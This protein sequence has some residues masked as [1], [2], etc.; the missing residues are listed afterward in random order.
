[1]QAPP[2]KPPVRKRAAVKA[3]ADTPRIK[4]KAAA[5]APVKEKPPGYVFGRPTSYRAEYCDDVIRMGG[6][7]FSI[8]EMAAEIGVNR[9]TLEVE[10][11]EKWPDF[12]RAFAQARLLSQAWWERQGRN[13]LSADKF[14]ASLY[15]RS[16]AARFP[17]DWRETS[18]VESTGKDG[19]KIEVE[20]TSG[21]AKEI[22]ALLRARKTKSDAP[23]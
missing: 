12:S 1:M 7:G 15:S 5:A 9:V 22:M 17:A 13:G 11:P 2:K 20:T 4:I 14:Q 16:M 18:R 23:K 19:G 21:T 8:V 10:W 6:E 3:A